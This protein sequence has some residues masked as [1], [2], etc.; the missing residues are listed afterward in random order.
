MYPNY[1]LI[2]TL[3]PIQLVFYEEMTSVKCF[4]LQL[5]QQAAVDAL[6]EIDN[7]VLI[8]F[9]DLSLRMMFVKVIQWIH[10][11]FGD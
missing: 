10:F 8:A 5:V 6:R 7:S 9:L 1:Q 2:I 11:I 4:A 3:L